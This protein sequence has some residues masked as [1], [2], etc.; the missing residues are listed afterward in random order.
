MTIAEKGRAARGIVQVMLAVI[1]ALAAVR[2]V[3]MCLAHPDLSWRSLGLDGSG[4][5]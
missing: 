4:S 5:E 1:V 2:I 3:P